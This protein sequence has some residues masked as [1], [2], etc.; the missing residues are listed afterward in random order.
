[1]ARITVGFRLDPKTAEHLRRVARRDGRIVS[2][3]LRRLVERELNEREDP[4]DR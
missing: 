3:Y 2:A 1:M 4:E